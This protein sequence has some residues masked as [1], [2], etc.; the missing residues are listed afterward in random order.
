MKL[1]CI[2][3]IW[4]VNQ[5]STQFCCNCTFKDHLLW[6]LIHCFLPLKYKLVNIS[7]H[8]CI[9]KPDTSWNAL[10]THSMATTMS[11]NHYTC[12]IL[13]GWVR[14]S[15]PYKKIC[16]QWSSIVNP[17]VVNS[18]SN[19]TPSGCKVFIRFHMGGSVGSTQLLKRLQATMSRCLCLSHDVNYHVSHFSFFRLWLHGKL[20]SN[21][22]LSLCA[23][24][25]TWS[26]CFI[27]ATQQ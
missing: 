21:C 3:K 10:L 19:S 27:S 22:S 17:L 4:S 24:E 23:L 13:L 11:S 25:C 5:V 1:S 9:P 26:N 18:V 20:L 14:V 8:V 12:C 15:A 2:S 7:T 6:G 16:Y